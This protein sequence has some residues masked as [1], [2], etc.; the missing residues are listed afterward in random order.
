MGPKYIELHGIKQIA[1]NLYEAIVFD[2]ISK[3]TRF[4]LVVYSNNAEHKPPRYMKLDNFQRV[5][6]TLVRFA[7]NYTSSLEH[8]ICKLEC[9]YN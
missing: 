9:Y 2:D 8:S 7:I 1:T 6:D 5:T 3:Y 4:N